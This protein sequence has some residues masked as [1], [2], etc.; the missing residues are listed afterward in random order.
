MSKI[1]MK[2]AFEKQYMEVPC[3]F[4]DYYMTDCLPVYPLIYIFSLRKIMAGEEITLKEI[5]ETFRLT[6]SDVTRAWAHWE[7]VGIVKISNNINKNM[8]IT[9]L[10]VVKPS[11][12][13]TSEMEEAV[14]KQVKTSRPQYSVQELAMYRTESRDVERLFTCA[15]EA[16]GKMLTYNDMNIIF[17]FHDFLRLPLDV[18]EFLLTYCR[19][20]DHRNLRYIEKCAIDWHDNN[21]NDLETAMTYVQNFDKNYRTILHY[22]GLNTGYPT[23]SHKK[24][25]DRW[26]KEWNISLE[27]IAL[28]CDKSVD[29]INKPN[30]KYVDKILQDWHKKNITTVEEVEK[31]EA[32]FAKTKETTITNSN[33]T[34]KVVKAKPNRFINFNQRENDYSQLEQ[35]ERAYLAKK[36]KV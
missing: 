28:A 29:Q 15:E 24:Y 5:S 6:E 36:L 9:F 22:M 34:A 20:N 11:A 13:P 3:T 12:E 21:I 26:T 2:L 30:F 27:L 25:M 4:V 31:A 1:S 18:I 7:N 14:V 10:P 33:T 17:G 23:P 16:L 32:E 35:L 19:D 8:E